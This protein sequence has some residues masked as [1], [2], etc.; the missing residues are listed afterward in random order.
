LRSQSAAHSGLGSEVPPEI[1]WDKILTAPDNSSL[2]IYDHD[3]KI[4]FCHWIAT[5]GA[6]TKAFN[7][8]L[9]DDYAPGDPLPQ[10]T[11]YELTLEG[12]STIFTTNRLRFE[13]HLRLSTNETWQDFRW[14][15]RIRP[16]AW[17]IHAVAVAQRIG[18]KI[19]D[20]GAVWKKTFS[21]S[22]FQHPEALMDSFGGS[23]ALDIAGAA[24]LPFLKEPLSQA[25]LRWT[26][27]EDWM[28]FGH[29]K[30]RV[31][32]LQ[33]EF[34]G[35]HLYIFTS[36]A[37]EIMWVEAPNKLTLRSEAFSHF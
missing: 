29:S 18:V 12:N 6:A 20:D 17:D 27:H 34:L 37:G 23:G 28:Q 7:Q 16:V 9:Q 22:D 2:E 33:T 15:G 26:A 8:T 19:N 31:Y 35:Q 30:V 21:F 1:V 14:S 13:A 24:A 10:P 25:A 4:G 32:R 36:R 5:T 3:Q 11:S